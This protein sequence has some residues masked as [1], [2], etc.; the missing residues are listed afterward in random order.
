[1]SV[2]VGKSTLVLLYLSLCFQGQ[3]QAA[4]PLKLCLELGKSEERK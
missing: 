2:I 1:M 4:V 3:F